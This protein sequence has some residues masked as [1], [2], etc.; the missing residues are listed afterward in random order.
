MRQIDQVFYQIF[1]S[2]YRLFEDILYCILLI[3][4]IIER[5]LF[6]VG[7]YLTNFCI[8]VYGENSLCTIYLLHI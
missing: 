7:D 3:L 2:L 8:Q 5:F 4:K 6:C 1:S